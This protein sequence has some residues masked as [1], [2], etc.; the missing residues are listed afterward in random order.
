MKR[1]VPGTGGIY[2]TY[3]ETKSWDRKTKFQPRTPGI[4]KKNGRLLQEA[5]RFVL[6]DTVGRRGEKNGQPNS[7]TTYVAQRREVMGAYHSIFKELVV[8][9]RESHPT[10]D[11]H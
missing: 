3:W 6:Y 1:Q 10:N 11:T 4:Q 8:A 2:G 7:V 9:T 5:S